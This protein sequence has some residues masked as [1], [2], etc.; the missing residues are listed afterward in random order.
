MGTYHILLEYVR[1][2]K[3]ILAF[4]VL[5]V[6]LSVASG[7]KSCTTLGDCK[8]IAQCVRPDENKKCAA[9]DT[10]CVCKAGCGVFDIFL[11]LGATNSTR[12]YGNFCS[13]R[14]GIIGSRRPAMA[15][16]TRAAWRDFPADMPP[17]ET[18]PNCR[19]PEPRT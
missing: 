8:C 11:P 15:M 1:T 18:H 2:M 4:G 10:G 7:L 12:V 6:C 16:C 9:G 17:Y 3:I 19:K 14:G 5:L 13:C